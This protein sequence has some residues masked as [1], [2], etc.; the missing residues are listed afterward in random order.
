[1]DRK[2]DCFK[3]KEMAIILRLS[4]RRGGVEN[5]MISYWQFVE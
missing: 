4:G 2:E 3:N 1:M 5:K